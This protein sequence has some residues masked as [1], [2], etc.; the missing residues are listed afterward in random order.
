MSLVVI[1]IA[2]LLTV[3]GAV[4][5]VSQVLTATDVKAG[6]ITL[7]LHLG[8]VLIGPAILVAYIN[9]MPRERLPRA[10][11]TARIGPFARRSQADLRG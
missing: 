9:F 10:L 1:A 2:L 6:L 8:L 4:D 5:V 3:G 7:V 11:E